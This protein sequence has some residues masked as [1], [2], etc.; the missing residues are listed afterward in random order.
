MVVMLL[1]CR[2]GLRRCHTHPQPLWGLPAGGAFEVLLGVG[3]G[4]HHA[5]MVRG[6]SYRCC[7]R[8]GR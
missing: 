6:F 4:P 8:G 1:A 2:L 3:S 5:I 7:Q